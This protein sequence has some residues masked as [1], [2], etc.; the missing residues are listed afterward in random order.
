[1]ARPPV[2]DEDAPVDVPT[3]TDGIVTLRAHRPDDAPRVVE[4]C[5]DAATERWTTVPAPY[6]DSHATTFLD[7]VVPDA[8]V[9]GSA[10]YFAI[11]VDGRFAGTID[12]RFAGD[13][14]AEVGFGVHPDVRGRGVMRRAL[15]LTL[16]WGFAE[17]DL[18]VVRW[19]AQRGNWGSRR[20][21]WASGF[22]FGP[23]VPALLVQRGAR[24]DAWTA[25]IGRD[26]P[27]EP[28]TRWLDTTPLAGAH[29]RL[30][31][32]TVTDG[33][34]LVEAAHDPVLR[35]GIPE[36]PLPT[37][38]DDVADYLL[39]VAEGAAAGGRVAW[40]VTDAGADEVLG[41]VAIFGFD[42][43]ADGCAEVGFWSHPRGRGRG[44][45]TEAVGL[46][47]DHARSALGVRRLDL[48]TAADNAGARRLAERVG[49]TL[50]GVE[51]AT[52]PSVGGGW[53]DTARY[54]LTSGTPSVSSAAR[55]RSA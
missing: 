46:V 52:S 45:M 42:E 7:E 48:L 4:Q 51:T 15:A 24:R 14:T 13:G 31:P 43:V 5:R 27:R 21:A 54:E 16:D 55:S 34:A 29:V 30:R 33:P 49:F 50:V 26:D 38:T 12:L 17:R 1:L 10:A 41:N 25:W 36:S 18:A 23:T 19:R 37:S 20:V 28:T 6:D 47:V 22:R 40:C 9:S 32:W 8:W 11:E 39:R 44:A 53:R 35:A 2:P 3:L